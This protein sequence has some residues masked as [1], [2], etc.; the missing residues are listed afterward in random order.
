MTTLVL[1]KP[2]IDR[3]ESHGAIMRYFPVSGKVEDGDA[4]C[5]DGK[6]VRAALGADKAIGVAVSVFGDIDDWN[7]RTQAYVCVYGPLFG[8][9]QPSGVAD[10][11]EIYLSAT[12]PGDLVT[13]KQGRLVGRWYKS[14]AVFI[15]PEVDK[16]HP[17]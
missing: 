11:Q 4:V 16:E 12:V 3:S 8:Y 15:A 7:A 17:E 6:R 13:E 2:L 10:G 1:L 14:E 5:F 9:E